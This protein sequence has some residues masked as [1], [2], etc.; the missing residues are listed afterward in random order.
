MLFWNASIPKSSQPLALYVYC[1]KIL[2]FSVSESPEHVNQNHGM[3]CIVAVGERDTCHVLPTV[4]AHTKACS[5]VHADGSHMTP[6][7]PMYH[8]EY[9][10]LTAH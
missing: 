9:R 4:D 8:S 2:Y 10:V 7:A 6:N 1:S 3:L 5:V